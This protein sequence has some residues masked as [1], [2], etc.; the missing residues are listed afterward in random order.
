MKMTRANGTTDTTAKAKES[1]RQ[2]AGHSYARYT[3]A[4]VKKP[5]SAVY[6]ERDTPE[7]K[8]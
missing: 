1:P 3:L 4:N 8:T 5:Y 7:M 6:C 2:S